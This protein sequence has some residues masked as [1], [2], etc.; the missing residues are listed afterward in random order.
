MRKGIGNYPPG[1]KDFANKVKK[2]AGW[3][4][5]R[6]KH[7]HEPETGHCLTVHHLTMDK[8]EPFDHWWAFLP[9]CQRCHLIVQAKVDLNQFWMFEHSSWFMPFVAGF[10]AYKNGLPYD[11]E[12]VETH[13]EE[14]LLLGKPNGLRKNG[15]AT[16]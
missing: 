6:C 14:L 16:F 4:C 8:S 1:W 11:R 9:L 10:Y 13:I 7:P 12:Y 3:E 15:Q 5:I 2:E